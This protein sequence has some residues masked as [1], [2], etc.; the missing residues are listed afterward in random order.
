[1][2][3]VRDLGVELHPVDRRGRGPRAPATGT[4]VGAR[5][6]RESGRRGGD[7]VAVA[8][9]HDLVDGEV[10]EQ[11]RRTLDVQLGAAVLALPGLR[12]LAAE[13]ARDELRAVTDAEHGDARRRRPRDRCRARR[14]R[15]PTPD[16]PR[17]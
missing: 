11:Q 9:P 17:G 3:G 4:R 12:D 5:R 10:G 6:H 16:R 8:H 13:I 14:A 1:M 15:A 2:L 7:R